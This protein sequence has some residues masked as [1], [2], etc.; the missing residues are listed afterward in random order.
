M[1]IITITQP[2][3]RQTTVKGFRDRF[4]F[5]E[6]QAIYTAAKSVVDIQIFLDDLASVQDSIVNLDDPATAAGLQA[7]EAAGL[8]G[9]GRAAEILA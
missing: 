6:K 1:P 2:A 3:L 7:M 4:T 8:I 9:V 5:A